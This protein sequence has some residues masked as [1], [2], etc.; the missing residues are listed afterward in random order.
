MSSPP[1]PVKAHFLTPIPKLGLNQVE[2]QVGTRTM[3]VNVQVQW[4]AYLWVKNLGPTGPVSS[5][6]APRSRRR[7][8]R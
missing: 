8:S 6:W 5:Q 3:G 4:A 2:E 1:G 7:V